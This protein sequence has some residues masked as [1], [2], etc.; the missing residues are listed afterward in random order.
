[1]P[2]YNAE[3]FIREAIDSVLAQTFTDFELVIVDDGSTDSTGEII[4]SYSDERIKYFRKQHCGVANALNYGIKRCVGDYIARFDADDIMFSDRLE[5]QVATM[6]ANVN[7]DIAGFGMQWGNGKP[8]PEYFTPITRALTI[9]LFKK[10][11]PMSH[12]T[13]IMRSKSILSLPFIYEP[14]YSCEDFK[15]WLTAIH[16]GLTIATFSKP[17][18]WYRQ[19]KKQV[20]LANSKKIFSDAERAKRSY[21]FTDDGEITC[22]IAGRNEGVEVEKTMSSIRAT[23]EGVRILFID[24]A[25]EDGFDY[26][27][28]CD[29]YKAKYVRNDRPIGSA[30]SKNKGVYL[31]ET[32]YFC[33]F[34]CHMRLYDDKWDV[35]LLEAL[36]AN[37]GCIIT[38]SSLPMSIN[39][40]GDYVNEN[41]LD[42]SRSMTMGAYVNL[43]EEGW[44]FTEKWATNMLPGMVGNLNEVTSV[45]GAVYASSVEH[46]KKIHGFDGLVFYG[47]EEPF[48]SIK[49]WLSGGKCLLI[50]N[51]Q[52]GHLYRSSQ[53]FRMPGG[54]LVANQ[55]ANQL[56]FL[57]RCERFDE[58]QEELRRRVGNAAYERSYNMLDLKLIENERKYFFENVAKVKLSEFGGVNRF[59]SPR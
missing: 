13:V 6:D 21:D 45:L 51:W 19:H 47:H 4:N 10:G 37:E 7:V 56:F 35:N 2:A 26:K 58:Y 34:D 40:D 24:D 22:V 16:K 31:V 8:E 29:E 23:A 28:V 36:K 48:I 52:V 18:I 25:S 50:R 20:V 42:R 32:P 33:L 41:G 53:P 15:L 59:L 14:Y 3:E 55:I 11:N 17:V 38:S 46:W 43:H 30:G 5:Y 57:G 44:E 27:S 1:M 49:T 39:D 54:S 12:P 9:D